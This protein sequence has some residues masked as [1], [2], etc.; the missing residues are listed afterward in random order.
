MFWWVIRAS[1]ERQ[2]VVSKSQ[3]GREGERDCIT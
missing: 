2:L 3:K 1:F